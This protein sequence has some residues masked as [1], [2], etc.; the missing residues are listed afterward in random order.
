M[1]YR[2]IEK[3]IYK[4]LPI[5]FGCHCRSDRS[6]FF[7]G[8]QFPIC[9]RCTGELAGILVTPILW[10]LF[11][12]PSI[13]V[14]MGMMV[15]LILDGSVQY[16]TKYESKNWIRFLTGFIFGYGLFCLFMI[17]IVETSRF[18]YQLG[19]KCLSS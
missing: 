11:G 2:K 16:F 17:S 10:I 3:F 5:F 4:W 12:R 18:G 13:F 14:C 7:H 6:F 19:K 9:A 8:K 1:D 15:P